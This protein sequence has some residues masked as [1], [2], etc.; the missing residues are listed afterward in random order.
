MQKFLNDPN[1]FVKEMLEGILLAHSEELRSLDDI[2]SLVRGDA[3]VPNKVGIVTGGGSG[4]L[5]L[6]L[7]YVGQGLLDGVAVGDVFASPT[8]EQILS[9]TKAVD[10]GAGVLYLYGNYGGDVMNFDLAGELAEMDGITTKTVVGADDIA[11]SPKGDEANRRGIA[12]IVMLYK[13]AGAKADTGATLDQVVATTEHAASRTRSFGVALSPMILP[14]VG[15]PTFEVESGHM[16]IGMGIHG[17]RG[18]KQ[19]PLASADSVADTLVNG[20]LA[21]MDIPSG[22]RV[23]VLVNGLGSTPKEELY[24]LY[25]RIHTNLLERGINI[26]RRWIGEYVTSLEMA[27]ASLSVMV[28]DE[29]L[30]DLI[31]APART[32]F[33]EQS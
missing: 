15:K 6:F 7:G 11:S 32:P 4:H 2:H 10:S 22:S 27:G 18:V 9:V 3:P 28:L 8:T 21:D 29:E 16:E 31:D 26:H 24:V 5:P 23:A 25:R 1:N 33:F 12:G 17:E 14:A 20:I 13:I 19:T 30:S